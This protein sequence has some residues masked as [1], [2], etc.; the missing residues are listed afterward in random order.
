[1]FRVAFTL[2][3]ILLAAALIAQQPP[4]VEKSKLKPRG[5]TL[6]VGDVVPVFELSDL[7]GKRAVSLE[8]LKG[9]PTVLIFGSC[10]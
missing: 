3:C 2:A 4:G 10:T 5:G 9:K 7:K 8:S 1:M 6:K